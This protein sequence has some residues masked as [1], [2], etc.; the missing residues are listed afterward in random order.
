MIMKKRQ[1]LL[2]M[3][4]DDR[5]NPFFENSK[6]K[7][8]LFFPSGVRLRSKRV[9]VSEFFRVVRKKRRKNGIL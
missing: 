1:K 4:K 2:I 7:N 9:F 6:L 8:H 3:N 5:M